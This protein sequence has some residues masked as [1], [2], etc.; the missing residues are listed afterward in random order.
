MT[1]KL[2]RE[3]QKDILN[4]IG[5]T[6]IIDRGKPN[7]Q[8]NCPIHGE[9][10]PSMGLKVDDGIVHCFSCHFSGS[11][12]WL[13]YKALPDEFSSL[14]EAEDWIYRT[15]G[16]NVREDDEKFSGRLLKRYGE[17]IYTSPVEK[18]H[19]VKRFELPKYYL[20]PFKSGKE[21]YKYF[22]DRGFT[23]DTMQEYMIGRD[24]DKKTVT[25]P[26]F[27]RDG[28]LGGVIGRYIDKNR[29]KN[30]RYAVYEF[31][32][33]TLLYPIH[34]FEPL[35]YKGKRVGVLV[36]G[37]LD[38]LWCHQNGHREV[39]AIQ[40]NGLTKTQAKLLGELNLDILVLAYDN[41]KGGLVA[42]DITKKILGDKYILKYAKY[43]EGIKDAQ[44]LTKG[45]IDSMIYKA[46]DGGKILKRIN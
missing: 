20:A 27:H 40:G 10:T 6:K 25:I 11:I 32:K 45:Q 37:N 30:S 23:K 38:S 34:K 18:E 31:P 15:Y 39:L 14:R 12:E 1:S 41:D 17:D 44:E 19:E 9:N 42:K 7:I 33:G 28:V 8:L 13:L 46:L 5:V 4:Y 26:I 16:V 29:P 21:T 35:I 3:Q 2:T 24:L 22:F 36:E 43:P